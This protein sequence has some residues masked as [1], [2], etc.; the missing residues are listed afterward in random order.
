MLER[1]FQSKLIKELKERFPGCMVLKND[2]NYIQGIPD[3][4]IFYK[5]KWATLE[6]KY[7]NDDPDSI[8]GKCS[9]HYGYK[10]KNHTCDDFTNKAE[11]RNNHYA[12]KI[13][14]LEM[15]IEKLEKI[16]WKYL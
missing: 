16:I 10:N 12:Y 15:R 4:S 5:D 9:L 8:F 1:N 6:C 11:Y 3:L 7:F 2:P 13:H 14:D